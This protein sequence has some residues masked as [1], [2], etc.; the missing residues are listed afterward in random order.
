MFYLYAPA[1]NKIQICSNKHETGLVQSEQGPVALG[2]PTSTNTGEIFVGP[3]LANLQERLVQSEQG[4]V[5]L[6]TPT[7]TNTG[8][9]F[10]GLL[11]ANLQERLVQSEQCPV[12]LGTPTSTYTGEIFVG[13]RMVMIHVVSYCSKSCVKQPLKSRQNKD[14]NNKW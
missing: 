2:T 10:V 3:H 13:P 4:P 9:I 14:L 6:G 7:S 1:K 12:V 8:E 11:P 5:V